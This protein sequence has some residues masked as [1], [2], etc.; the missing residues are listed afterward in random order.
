LRV[1]NTITKASRLIKTELNMNKV[2]LLFVAALAFL[3]F[4]CS[5]GRKP[6]FGKEPL[7]LDNFG[8]N[9]DV[10]TFFADETLF[11]N[12]ERYSVK[13]DEEVIKIDNSDSTLKY[14][15]YSVSSSPV[16]DTL[17]QYD[18]FYFGDLE[19]VMDF[20]DKE[21]FMIAASQEHVSP[22]KIDTLIKD[23]SAEY[24][25]NA[26]RNITY[27]WKKDNKLTKLVL[28]MDS[29]LYADDSNEEQHHDVNQLFAK[30]Y[31]KEENVSITLYI[32]NPK[33]D[34]YL[35]KASST[36]GLLTKY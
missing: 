33:F 15:R 12:N 4:G 7:H 24:G 36:S 10:E 21:T 1:K 16:S 8:M 20:D 22:G 17:A 35:K 34:H 18:D 27:Q 19:V 30:A 28:D 26:P 25:D 3:L 32:T 31:H 11:R 6:Q 2:N 14:V 5:S 23:I 13:A 9:L 29:P